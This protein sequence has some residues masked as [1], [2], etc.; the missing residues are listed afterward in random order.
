MTYKIIFNVKQENGESIEYTIQSVRHYK[1]GTIASVFHTNSDNCYF[2]RCINLAEAEAIKEY[3]INRN[4]NIKGFHN[5]ILDSIMIIPI[6][7]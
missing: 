3:I 4:I 2:Y 7:N 5:L 6:I 1:D